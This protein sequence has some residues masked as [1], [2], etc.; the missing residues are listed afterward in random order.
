V[1]NIFIA[2]ATPILLTGGSTDRQSL[3]PII[4]FPSTG[5]TTSPPLPPP[6]EGSAT[7]D[8]NAPAVLENGQTI[9][10]VD[11]DSLED[12]PWRK[13]GANIAD[14]FNYGFDETAWREYVNRQKRFKN[15]RERERE[16][17]FTVRL[18]FRVLMC[19][20]LAN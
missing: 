3:T 18:C 5:R 12:K 1:L 14:Y 7:T 8:P 6:S 2:T 9:L 15:E 20:E 11:I 10:D 4:P 17:P 16:N 19:E 13:S